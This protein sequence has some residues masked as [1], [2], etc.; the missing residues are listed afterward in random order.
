MQGDEKA[1]RTYVVVPFGNRNEKEN[2]SRVSSEV[3][4]R[5]LSGT[6]ERQAYMRFLCNVPPDVKFTTFRST[7]ALQHAN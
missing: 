6:Q 5:T 4:V 2:L 7:T 3:V 1:W